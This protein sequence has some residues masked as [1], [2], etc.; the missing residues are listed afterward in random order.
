MK[1]TLVRVWRK[2]YSNLKPIIYT[3]PRLSWVDE[4]QKEYLRPASSSFDRINILHSYLSE[5]YEWP[6]ICYT[7]NI[8]WTSLTNSLEFDVFETPV[9][10][11][12]CP[13]WLK[14]GLL[15]RYLCYKRATLRI[16]FGL[17]EKW[18]KKYLHIF[19]MNAYFCI[20]LTRLK[21]I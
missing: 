3:G 13:K 2:I 18:A 21:V 1:G 5:I 10:S 19:V 15:L 14:K 7:M 16:Y 11:Q 12:N 6:T 20:I 9:K 4:C 8:F 17:E